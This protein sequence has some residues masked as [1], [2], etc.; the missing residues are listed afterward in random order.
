MSGC[1]ISRPFQSG[2]VV[3][4]RCGSVVPAR[5]NAHGLAAAVLIAW[6]LFAGAAVP[7]FIWP[8]RT[9]ESPRWENQKLWNSSNDVKE[10]D[11]HRA[12]AQHSKEHSKE[13]STGYSVELKPSLVIETRCLDVL[14]RSVKPV[15]DY[16]VGFFKLQPKNKGSFLHFQYRSRQNAS[17][18]KLHFSHRCGLK[19]T[20]LSVRRLPTHHHHLKRVSFSSEV[21]LQK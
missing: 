7:P 2:L 9:E 19:D 8:S 10:A 20:L 1:G 17:A 4:S 13:H 12:L 5:L 3:L 11:L 6:F 18:S 14:E 16:D 21:S 15:T